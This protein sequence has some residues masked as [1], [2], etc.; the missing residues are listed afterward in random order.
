ML[1]LF[2]FQYGLFMC[3]VKRDLV[4]T[5]QTLNRLQVERKLPVPRILSLFY[6][7]C[8]LHTSMIMEMNNN[9]IWLPKLQPLK[10]FGK[11]S[12]FKAPLIIF[13]LCYCFFFFFFKH[14]CT[15]ENIAVI[16]SKVCKI[17]WSSALNSLETHRPPQLVH[18]CAELKY[19]TTLR[20][21]VWAG[22]VCRRMSRW[23]IYLCNVSYN[24]LSYWC[25]FRL[26]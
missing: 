22:W 18:V 23:L 7:L 13:F 16:T 6:S 9:V 2:C 12:F 8:I 24:T 14:F 15:N 4:T 21:F 10:S 5:P 19:P 20:P 25:K 3:L 26:I 1:C 17:T 11:L